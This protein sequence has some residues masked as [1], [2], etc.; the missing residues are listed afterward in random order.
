MRKFLI[1]YLFGEYWWKFEFQK[2]YNQTSRFGFWCFNIL[3]A[4]CIPAILGY[5]ITADE[6][7][8]DY[9]WIVI[10]LVP[11]ILYLGFPLGGMGYFHRYPPQWEELSRG[12]KWFLGKMYKNPQGLDRLTGQQWKEFFDIQDEFRSRYGLKN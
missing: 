2:H 3:L 4:I 8:F 10:P 1:K 6:G 9:L 7:W 11:V 12:Q 5:L